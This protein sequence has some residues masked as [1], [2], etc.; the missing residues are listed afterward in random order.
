MVQG[1]IRTQPDQD[2]FSSAPIATPSCPAASAPCPLGLGFTARLATQNTNRQR[3]QQSKSASL[4]GVLS[5]LTPRGWG[6]R[7]CVPAGWN[8]GNTAQRTTGSKTARAATTTGRSRTMRESEWRRDMQGGLAIRP[9]SPSRK[10]ACKG[11]F[12]FISVPGERISSWQ[13]M[14]GDDQSTFCSKPLENP[15]KAS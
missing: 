14:S 6:A 10:V 5:T 9:T 13:K 12:N 4:Q 2:L 7:G 15:M 8:P 11:N 3:M 1:L